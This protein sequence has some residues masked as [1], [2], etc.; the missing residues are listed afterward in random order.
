MK[1]IDLGKL[2]AALAKATPGEVCLIENGGPALDPDENYWAIR[3]GRGASFDGSDGFDVSGFI[4]SGDANLLM[5]SHNALPDIL[6]ELR[7]LRT[8]T[9]P[10]PISDKH[11]DGNWWVV[12]EP[13]CERWVQAQ[14][15]E[16]AQMWVRPD[17]G[18]VVAPTHAILMPP[19]PE[20]E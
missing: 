2:E 20:G 1:R 18:Y 9:T 4:S 8:L 12:W 13:F 11:K 19:A 15:R 14:W 7:H 16:R 10:E 17:D 5:S 3:K 6:A